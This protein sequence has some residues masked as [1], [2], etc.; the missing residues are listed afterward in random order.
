MIGLETADPID[1]KRLRRAFAQIAPRSSLIL[2][3]RTES[4]ATDAWAI[5]VDGHLFGVATFHGRIPDPQYSQAVEGALFWPGAGDLMGRHR[6]FC[7]IAAADLQG[8]HGLAR[9]QSIALTRLLAAMIDVIPGL[10]VMWAD[11]RSLTAP[12]RVM[13]APFE[14][15]RGKWPLDLWLGWRHFGNNTAHPPVIGVRTVG[16]AAYL[17]FEIELSPTVAVEEKE[18]LRILFN[19]VA[20]LMN[21]GDIIRDGQLVHVSG[22]RRT[23]YNLDLDADGRPNLARLVV[24]DSDQPNA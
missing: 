12:D 2:D 16:A 23:T 11:A 5:E 17:G 20:Y 10:G 8:G 15:D 3:R 6:A 14:I 24:V 1:P 18:P 4:A 9:A 19:A 21:F 22:E 7:T 13:A